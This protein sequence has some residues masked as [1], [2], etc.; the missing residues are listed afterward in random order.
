MELYTLASA[1]AFQTRFTFADIMLILD[2]LEVL[3]L[4]E[5]IFGDRKEE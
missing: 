5:D 3:V 4:I 2:T 1:S